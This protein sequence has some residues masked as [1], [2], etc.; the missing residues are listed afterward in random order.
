MDDPHGIIKT[1]A[2]SYIAN[3]PIMH[4]DAAAR[5]A[6]AALDGYLRSSDFINIGSKDTS[7]P[8]YI[9]VEKREELRQ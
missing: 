4:P 5:Q 2:D 9:R 8:Q 7:G 6:M 3:V 1:F